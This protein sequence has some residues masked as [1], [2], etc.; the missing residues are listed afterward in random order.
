MEKLVSIVEAM[1][2]IEKQRAVLVPEKIRASSF[3]AS[4]GMTEVYQIGVNDGLIHARNAL[5]YM[6]ANKC[7]TAPSEK[8]AN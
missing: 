1:E 6:E 5:S 4:F 7:E 8:E 2:L 3:E